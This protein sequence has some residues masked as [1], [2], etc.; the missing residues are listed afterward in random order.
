M[1]IKHFLGQLIFYR[2]FPFLETLY[3]RGHFSICLK[4]LC[5]MLSFIAQ[6]GNYSPVYSHIWRPACVLHYE[7]HVAFFSP[8]WKELD[9]Q[10]TPNDLSLYGY[11]SEDDTLLGWLLFISVFFLFWKNV[12]LFI[13]TYRVS[14]RGEISS[15]ENSWSCCGLAWEKS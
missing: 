14:T 8:L 13:F 4:V 3:V 2:C 11:I 15:R 12:G 9:I 5:I 1:P 7:R 10:P 6:S